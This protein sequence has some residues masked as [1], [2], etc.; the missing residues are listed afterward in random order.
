MRR[1][2][3]ALLV[4]VLTTT[5]APLAAAQSRDYDGPRGNAP[6]DRG[7]RDGFRDGERDAR[8]GR[9]F[10]HDDDRLLSRRSNPFQRGYADG[11]R[12]GYERSR[13]AWRSGRGPA[14]PGRRGYGGYQD[15][16]FARGYSD[17]YEKGHDDGEDRDRYDPVR[18][19]DYRSADDGYFR[20]Y[21]PKSAYENNYR[22]GFRQGYEEGYRNGVRRR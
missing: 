8:Q 22:A 6:Y 19:R 1:V 2:L 14:A 9:R 3:A 21:G 10:D 5:V 20:D 15:P 18:H 7:Y 13:G 17:G 16:A 12:A 11:Y 4:L